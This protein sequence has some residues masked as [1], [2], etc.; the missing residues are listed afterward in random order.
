MRSA[1]LA[2]ACTLLAVSAAAFGQAAPEAAGAAAAPNANGRIEPVAPVRGA[3]RGDL[4]VAPAEAPKRAQAL[5]ITIL[6]PD[7]TF[8]NGQAVPLDQ[9]LNSGAPMNGRRG[10]GRKVCPA[11]MESRGDFCG[12]PMGDVLSR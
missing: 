4:P 2:L 11:G 8:S 5:P 10:V 1:H 7:T 3:A 9:V 6:G 12:A